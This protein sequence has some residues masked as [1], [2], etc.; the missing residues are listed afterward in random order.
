MLVQ[1]RKL[2]EAGFIY[3]HVAELELVSLIVV[4][5]KKKMVSIMCA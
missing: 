2:L 5:S 3:P 4:V 1:V